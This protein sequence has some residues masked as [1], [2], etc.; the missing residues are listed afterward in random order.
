[1]KKHLVLACLTFVTYIVNGQNVDSL[2][3]A[4]KTAEGDKKVKANNELFRAYINSDPVKAI[5]YAHEALTLANAI[6]DKRGMAAAY[7]NLGVSYRNQ[8][9]LD[10]AL[11]N[12]MKALAIYT[13]IQ[14]G[15]GVASTKNNIAN[16]Y[17]LKKDYGQALKYFEESNSGF[18][19]IGNQQLIIGSMNNLGNLHSDLQ[20]YDQALNFYTEAY[21][22][23]EKSGQ[24]FADPLSNIGNLYYRRGNFQ[25]AIEY[26]GRAMDIAKKNNDRITE[27]SLLA[28]IGEA[29][30]KGGQPAEAQKRLSQALALANELQASFNMPQILK[31]M[32]TNYARQ[33]KMKEAYETLVK[34][35]EMQEKVYGEESTRKIS[36]MGVALDLKEKER[37]IDELRLSGEVKSLQIKNTQ[38]IITT[39]ILGIVAVVAVLNLWLMGR[40]MRKLK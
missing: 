7:N 26:Y 36:Q 17:S 31:S 5:A 18:V 10:V 9:A 8:G 25:R 29:Y 34:H 32:A 24:Q 30:G 19:A 6:G 39:V 13:E 16:I 27:L 40:R 12:Y 22:L 11:E 23:A 2:E 37:Q 35:N 4:L 28:N 1:M 3:N 20:L 21:K 33:G 15:E 38:F 14:Y